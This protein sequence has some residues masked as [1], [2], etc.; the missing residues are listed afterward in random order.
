MIEHPDVQSESDGRKVTI[1]RVGVKNIRYPIVVEDR[2]NK[3]QHTVAKID[4][5][6][7]LDSKERGTHMSRFLEVLNRYHQENLVAN[8]E[9]FLLE[10]KKE[11]KAQ[12]AY[13]RFEFPYFIEKTAPVSRIKSLLSYECIFE[14]AYSDEYKL[15]IGVTVPVTTLCPCSKEISE[16]GAHNQRSYVTVEVLFKEFVWLEELIELVEGS[17]S[18]EIYSLLK[19]A[20]EKYVTE[21]AYNNPHFVEDVVRELTLKL[22]ADSRIT[23]FKVESLNQES[24]HDHDAYAEV[25]FNG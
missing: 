8:L 10:I 3:T 24:I 13:A 2:K 22:R 16:K 12:A 17:A 9:V 18:C 21:K 4:L 14:A 25:N 6:V 19:R 5:Y 20:D 7:E 15:M 1:N 11:L 23:S